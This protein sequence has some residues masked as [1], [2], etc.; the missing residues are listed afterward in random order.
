MQEFADLYRNASP[1]DQFVLMLLDRIDTLEDRMNATVDKLCE[2][3][4]ELTE[5]KCK[6]K[7]KDDLKRQRFFVELIKEYKFHYSNTPS[8]LHY[9]MRALAISL[10]GWQSAYRKCQRPQIN[11]NDIDRFLLATTMNRN[12]LF[13]REAAQVVMSMTEEDQLEFLLWDEIPDLEDDH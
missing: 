12:T 5:L 9:Y 1:R 4:T 13:A 10:I 11:E 3:V 2:T 7:A 6:M 8:D